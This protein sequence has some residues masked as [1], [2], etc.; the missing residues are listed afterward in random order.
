MFPFYPC[1]ETL[2]VPSAGRGA[3][4][5]YIERVERSGLQKRKFEMH[6]FSFLKLRAVHINNCR[7]GFLNVMPGICPEHFIH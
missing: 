6:C 5:C 4:F 7:R 3:S 1:I 2:F